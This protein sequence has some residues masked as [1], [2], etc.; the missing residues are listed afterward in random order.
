[1]SPLYFGYHIRDTAIVALVFVKNT[2]I[3]DMS[4]LH[5]T[6]EADH[7]QINGYWL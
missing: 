7:L 3:G 2:T 5:I 1:M 4:K 6:Y